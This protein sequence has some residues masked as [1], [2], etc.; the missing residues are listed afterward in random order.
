[1]RSINAVP[2]LQLIVNFFFEMLLHYIADKR[3]S[4][5]AQLQLRLLMKL[6]YI[7]VVFSETCTLDFGRRHTRCC[8]MG[9][10]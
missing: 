6:P 2:S 5:N 8:L 3:S 9:L 10:S 4:M 7:G 1:M